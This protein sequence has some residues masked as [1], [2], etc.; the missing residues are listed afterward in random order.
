[1]PAKNKINDVCHLVNEAQKAVI[2]AQG[3]VDLER[4]QHAQYLVLQAKQFLNE[5]QWTED[6]EAQFLRTKELIRQ[7]EETLHALESIE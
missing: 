6:E 4:F 3:N 1:M 7:L 2:E 5:Q